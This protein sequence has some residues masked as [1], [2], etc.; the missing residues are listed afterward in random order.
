MASKPKRAKGLSDLPA[1]AGAPNNAAER[2][3]RAEEAL[4]TLTRMAGIA[5]AEADE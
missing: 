1:P 2:R 3:Y 5:S 4:R